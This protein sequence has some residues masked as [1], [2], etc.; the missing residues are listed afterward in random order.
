MVGTNNGLRSVSSTVR[1][2]HGSNA[3]ARDGFR[4]Y[5][6]ESRLDI[7]RLDLDRRLG[8]QSRAAYRPDRR[9]VHEPGSGHARV[10]RAERLRLE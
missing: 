1:R 4:G 2:V 9:I 8:T 6:R 5:S 3:G 10:E 7:D